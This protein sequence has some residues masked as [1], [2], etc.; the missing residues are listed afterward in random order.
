MT[1]R[2]GGRAILA[3]IAVALALAAVACGRP[4]GAVEIPPG[5]L[6]FGVQRSASPKIGIGK[7][8]AFAIAS[9]R[10]LLGRLP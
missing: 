10:S 3:P 2:R 9:H 6:P 5:D 8:R 1:A 4:S 7:P